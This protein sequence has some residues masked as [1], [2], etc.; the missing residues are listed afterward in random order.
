MR[1]TLSRSQAQAFYD[2]IGPH[3]DTQSFYER[4]ALD[5][6]VEHARFDDAHALFELGC[7][8][9]RF[10][11]RVLRDYCPPDAHYTGVDLSSTMVDLAR[12]QLAP[13]APRADVIHTDGRLRWDRPGGSYDRVLATYVLDLLSDD[14]VEAFLDEAHRLL[15]RHGRL[16]LAGLTW[17]QTPLSRVAARVWDA[18]HAWNPHLV[19]GCRPMAVQSR[20]LP[21]RWRVRHA[22]V[23][24]G[25]AIPSEVLVAEAVG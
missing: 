5:A 6:L 16:C 25:W 18:V 12:R 13:F 1:D 2:R 9:G 7:G 19:G 20:L 17:G 4:P 14:D 11:A 24:T 8:T 22:E 23:V 10:A 3:Q 21:E 15:T